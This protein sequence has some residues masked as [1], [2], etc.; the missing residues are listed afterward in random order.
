MVTNDPDTGVNTATGDDADTWLLRYD[1]SGGTA[2]DLSPLPVGSTC[3]SPNL[4]FT[5]TQAD[6][7]SQIGSLGLMWAGQ[8]LPAN[9]QAQVV[10]MGTL[11]QPLLPAGGMAN[12]AA[13]LAACQTVP[14]QFWV[15]QKLVYGLGITQAEIDAA[16]AG[17]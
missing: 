3:Q 15:A 7:Q 8:P 17:A 9:W 10:V 14:S 4:M 2:L 13:A 11:A 5:G 6:C 16:V 12:L 1:K